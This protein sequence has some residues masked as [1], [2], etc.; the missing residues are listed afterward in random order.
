MTVTD[1]GILDLFDRARK[2]SPTPVEP[3]TDEELKKIDTLYF[4]AG[5]RW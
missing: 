3:F 4:A 5:D 1:H 2:P